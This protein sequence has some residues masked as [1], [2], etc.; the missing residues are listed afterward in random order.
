MDPRS[1]THSPDSSVDRGA[2]HEHVALGSDRIRVVGRDRAHDSGPVIAP[3]L[4]MKPPH[5]RAD[6]RLSP[7]RM[8]RA[9]RRE[10][11][12]ASSDASPSP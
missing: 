11:L 9:T 7:E 4:L 1:S 6:R 3:G 12:D 10:R 2:S 5:S 8:D